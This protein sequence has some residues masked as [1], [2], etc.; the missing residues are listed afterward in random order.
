MSNK[1]LP[2]HILTDKSVIFII[3][4]CGLTISSKNINHISAYKAETFIYN[5]Y[6]VH[7]EISTT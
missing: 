4:P 5:F 2:Y 1:S 7:N 3:T 6:F